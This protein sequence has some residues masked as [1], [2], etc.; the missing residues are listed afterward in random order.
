MY[1]HV[2][3]N[4]SFKYMNEAEI[5]LSRFHSKSRQSIASYYIHVDYIDKVRLNILN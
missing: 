3:K 1:D 5:I 2:C 4:M